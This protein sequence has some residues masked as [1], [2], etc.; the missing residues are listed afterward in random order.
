MSG[1]APRSPDDD[2]HWRRLYESTRT[3]AVADAQ[4]RLA[5]GPSQSLAHDLVA[6]AIARMEQVIASDANPPARA[7][8]RGCS[9]CCRQPVFLT[10]P[11]AVAVVA[12]LRATWNN[13][14]LAA[15]RSDLAMRIAEHRTLRED[16][17]L[18]TAG[19]PCVFLDED[20]A[21][22][23][24][25]VRPLICRGFMSSSAEACA[26][27]YIDPVNAPPPPVDV[28]AYTAARGVLH[29]LSAA[30]TD[31]GMAGGMGELNVLLA[32]LLSPAQDHT[33]A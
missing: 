9:W 23:I 25:G 6:E 29:G 16:R 7:C 11:E 4:R 12:H 21:C 30:L 1:A 22:T 2:P 13:D 27:R 18:L 20:N 15:L 17:R 8:K 10:A 3:A 33:T 32:Q 5:D 19:L 28:H 26:E 14:Q 24:H 31:A